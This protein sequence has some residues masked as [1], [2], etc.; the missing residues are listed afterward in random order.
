LVTNG[1]LRPCA[2][3][4]LFVV[5]ALLAACGA[6]TPHQPA[7]SDLALITE[8]L[9]DSL[10]IPAQEVQRTLRYANYDNRI[11]A[12]ELAI[13]GAAEGATTPVDWWLNDM[14]FIRLGGI[15]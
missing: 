7:P 14:G 11:Y 3:G 13:P 4:L 6:A 12:T 15:G 9:D 10:N 8:R 5:L 2:S 1:T